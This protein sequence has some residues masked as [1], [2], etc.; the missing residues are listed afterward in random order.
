MSSK[1]RGQKPRFRESV[2]ASRARAHVAL[3]QNMYKY[4]VNHQLIFI[5][6]RLCTLQKL[7][8]VSLP[9]LSVYSPHDVFVTYTYLHCPM[10]LSRLGNL[11]CLILQTIILFF[12]NAD[13]L[14]FAD[15]NH[16]DLYRSC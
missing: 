11:F 2:K 4:P 8:E 5:L 12:I 1:S 3:S 15:R 14:R 13:T 7:S 6:A 10:R 16:A 9:L